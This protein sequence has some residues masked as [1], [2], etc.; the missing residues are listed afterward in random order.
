MQVGFGHYLGC[1]GRSQDCVCE[2]LLDQIGLMSLQESGQYLLDLTLD[3]VHNL[4]DLF[5][6]GCLLSNPFAY[7]AVIGLQLG[8]D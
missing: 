3:S 1:L 7:G 8:L 5:L 4:L 6:L 2:E